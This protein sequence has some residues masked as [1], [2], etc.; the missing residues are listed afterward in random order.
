MYST[1]NREGF[2]QEV[3]ALDVIALA[4]TAEV[5]ADSCNTLIARRQL[6]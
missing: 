3:I 4:T 1:V 5:T 2:A 6:S